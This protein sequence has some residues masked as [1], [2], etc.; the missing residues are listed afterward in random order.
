MT[1]PNYVQK[2]V[3]D[4]PKIESIIY[5]E[6]FG[7]V[8]IMG[9]DGTRMIRDIKNSIPVQSLD[10]LL[11]LLDKED[12]PNSTVKGLLRLVENESPLSNILESIP[13]TSPVFIYTKQVEEFENQIKNYPHRRIFILE[14]ETVPIISNNNV[15]YIANG[16]GSFDKKLKEI[17]KS[18]K[19]R[20]HKFI[21]Y[22]GS[23]PWL[24]TL[25]VIN[26]LK[27][28]DESR[29]PVVTALRSLSLKEKLTQFYKLLR[30]VSLGDDHPRY[31][32]IHKG[33]AY[34]NRRLIEA[35]IYSLFSQNSGA[36]IGMTLFDYNNFASKII[37]P[38]LVKDKH[39]KHEEITMI[40]LLRSYKEVGKFFP[41]YYVKSLKRDIDYKTFLNDPVKWIYNLNRGVAS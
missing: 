1:K 25:D 41:K 23:K 26:C 36:M 35:P 12:I 17:V 39:G 11:R 7:V 38:S 3:K 15:S 18:E 27:Q 2:I 16:G 6:D 29:V 32:M 14:Q 21:T 40:E 10:L 19:L 9:G 5:P 13:K 20:I 31:D 34:R 33:Q 37:K 24:H 8:L 30:Q 22:D 4:S 28:M